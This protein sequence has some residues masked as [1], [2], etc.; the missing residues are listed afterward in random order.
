MPLSMQGCMGG[1]ADPANLILEDPV[2]LSKGLVLGRQQLGDFAA[3]DALPLALSQH[4]TGVADV[5]GGL[6][7]VARQ[8]PQLDARLG[9]LLY[10][11]P[12]T[13][14]I[15]RIRSSAVGLLCLE[16]GA[17]H[18]LDESVQIAALPPIAGAEPG[19]LRAKP[20]QLELRSEITMEDG[21]CVGSEYLLTIDSLVPDK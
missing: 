11:V 20:Q 8:H 2:L 18:E 1:I 14:A 19:T 17:G 15:A 5:D 16:S 3:D 12:D 6:H 21:D 13:L 7:F 4:A 9:Q 10:A